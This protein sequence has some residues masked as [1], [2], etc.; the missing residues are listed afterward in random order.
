MIRKVIAYLAAPILLAL[1]VL[2]LF[3]P[4]AQSN[5]EP[6]AL[7]TP[8]ATTPVVDT[9]PHG[10]YSLPPCITE[11]GAG[12]ALCMWDAQTMGNGMGTSVISGDCA[13]DYV[14][15][16]DVSALCVRLYAVPSSEH[17]YQGATIT[18]P[19]GAELAQECAQEWNMM[20][21]ETAKAEGFTLEECFKAQLGE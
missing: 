19:N 2:S 11:D 9:A 1:V 5:A 17:E 12:Q 20:D 18:V 8:S 16:E 7:P 21:D 13:P 3:T 15:G 10:G 4:T 14:G 6:I